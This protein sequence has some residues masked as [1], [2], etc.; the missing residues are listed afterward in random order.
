[1]HK[2]KSRVAG[3]VNGLRQRDL[4]QQAVQRLLTLERVGQ[5]LKRISRARNRDWVVD[6]PENNHIVLQPVW[7]RG[8]LRELVGSVSN[9]LFTSAT[10]PRKVLELLGLPKSCVYRDYPSVFDPARSPNLIL[11]CGSMKYRSEQLTFPTL[12]RRLG[13]ILRFGPPVRTVIHTV[14]YDR[15]F[16]LRAGLKSF[17]D[18]IIVNSRGRMKWAMDSYIRSRDGIFISPSLTTG[19]DLKGDLCRLNIMIKAP[20]ANTSSRIERLRYKLDKDYYYFRAVM[21]IRQALGR[22]MREDEDWCRNVMLDTDIG[23]LI[24]SNRHHLSGDFKIQYVNSV[25][26]VFKQIKGER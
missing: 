12:V 7:P 21:T 23:W 11:P 18:R 16:R 1:V 9:V 15:A 2:G 25:P 3:E 8:F 20:F 26:E 6:L 5:T 17:H 24:G 14:S 22:G 10:I 19:V 4:S 13:Q